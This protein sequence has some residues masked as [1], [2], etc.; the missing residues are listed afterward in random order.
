ML[1][2]EEK[3]TMM[4][5]L[6]N[7]KNALEIIER[8][9]SQNSE[10]SEDEAESNA[11]SI[12]IEERDV[13]NYLLNI[14]MK[15][16]LGGFKYVTAAILLRLEKND[17]I[18]SMTKELYPGIAKKYNTKA[19]RVEHGMR[20]SIER[21]IDAN[22]CTGNEAF[23]KLFK[24]CDLAKGVTNSDFISLVAVKIKLER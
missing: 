11:Q 18:I 10:L 8:I 15:P 20:H 14:G 21:M 24:G 13:V 12:K 22:V 5:A 17:D 16:S 9:M 7:L 23:D 2:I 6:R 4:E 1:S 3:S 19:Q